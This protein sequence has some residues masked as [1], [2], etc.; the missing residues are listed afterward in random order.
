MVD[1]STI[2]KN[3]CISEIINIIKKHNIKLSDIITTYI[4]TFNM[5]F[6]NEDKLI[7]YSNYLDFITIKDVL[8]KNIKDDYIF[9]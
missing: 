3:R 7:Q 1:N 6:S 2:K 8:Q 9:I 4:K 5:N